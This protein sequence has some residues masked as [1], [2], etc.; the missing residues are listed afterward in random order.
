MLP[1]DLAGIFVQAGQDAGCIV[2]RLGNRHVNIVR[3]TV[4]AA[5]NGGLHAAGDTVVCVAVVISM[6]DD[7]S[8]LRVDLP[9]GDLCGVIASPAQTERSTHIKIQ[10]SVLYGKH[11]RGI[12]VVQNI[13]RPY[14][15]KGIQIQAHQIAAVIRHKEITLIYSRA[16][17]HSQPEGFRTGSGAVIP[18]FYRPAG[19]NGKRSRCRIILCVQPDQIDNAVF[20]R[21]NQRI[22]FFVHQCGTVEEA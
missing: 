6:P 4:F 19:R 10:L 3:E 2:F 5:G 22:R 8:R 18:P 15:L 9:D 1:Q 21:I 14:K 16:V 20:A 7:L 12:G 13:L 17:F 11:R